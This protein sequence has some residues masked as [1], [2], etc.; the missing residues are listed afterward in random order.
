MNPTLQEI[1]DHH[2]IRKLLSTYCHG[3]DRGDEQRMARVYS[4]NSWDDHGT[5]KGPGKQFAKQLM[6]LL[7]E[8][9]QTIVHLLGQSLIKVHGDEAGAETYFLASAVAVNK[10]GREVANLLSGRYVD[11]LIREAGSWKIHKRVC[12]RDWSIS[13]DVAKD[14]IEK[15]TFIQGEMSGRDPSYAILGLKH[16]G[17]SPTRA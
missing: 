11:S 8:D 13:L 17:L 10:E 2:E 9:P 6:G 3:C 5:Y 4:D 1:V 16:P 7:A 12:V 15:G 14:W